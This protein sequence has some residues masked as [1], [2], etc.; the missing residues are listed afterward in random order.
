M[1][2]V[3]PGKL[4]GFFLAAFFCYDWQPK[5]QKRFLAWVWG[6]DAVALITFAG[7]LHWI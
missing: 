4:I 3:F 1:R 2:P 6:F 5:V 7:I